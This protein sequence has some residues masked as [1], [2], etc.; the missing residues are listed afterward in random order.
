M[1]R[2]ALAQILIILLLLA[3]LVFWQLA[4][5]PKQII[6][7]KVVG[8]LSKKEIFQEQ[9]NLYYDENVLEKPQQ[10]SVS[11]PEEPKPVIKPVSHSG[12]INPEG[13]YEVFG[14]VQNNGEET[15]YGVTVTVIF[16]DLSWRRV[17]EVSSLVANPTLRP[18]ERSAFKVVL[19]KADGRAVGSYVILTTTR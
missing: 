18:G 11:P 19:A 9:K 6:K 5:P 4:P 13:K 16:K 2:R 15:A 10:K 8:G 1:N 17:G 7:R 3:L 14:M 12:W